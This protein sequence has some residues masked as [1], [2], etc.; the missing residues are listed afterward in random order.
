MDEKE[1]ANECAA[2]PEE[3]KV[4]FFLIFFHSIQV[5]N[6]NKSVDSDTKASLVEFVCEKIKF[7]AAHSRFLNSYSL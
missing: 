6:I 7:A 4:R 5:A 1:A 3:E 2:P